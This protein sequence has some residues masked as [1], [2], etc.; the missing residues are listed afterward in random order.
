MMDIKKSLNYIKPTMVTLSLA[1]LSLLTACGGGGGSSN[2]S[3][4]N[5]TTP[6]PTVNTDTRT[7]EAVAFE[8]LNRNRT[9]CGFGALTR[10][11][12]LDITA[13][14][15]ANYM[16]VVSESNKLPI[17]SHE[18]TT[19]T[20][21][22]TTLANTGVVNPYFSGYSLLERLNPTTL[23][24][25]AVK[26]NYAE[27]SYAE[28]LAM[29]TL[30]TSNTNFVM[31]SNVAVQNRM[32]GLLAAPYHMQGLLVPQFKE[33]GIGYQEAKWLRDGI[34]RIG[35]ILEV[36]TA[37][38]KDAPLEEPSQTVSYPCEGVMT[39]YELTDEQPNPFA[40]GR[41][42]KIHPVGQ[43]IYVRA[44]SNKVIVDGS[45]TISYNGQSVGY[46]HKLMA[47]NDINKKLSPNEMV[48]IPDNKLQPNTT[49][50]V[51][52]LIMFTDGTRENRSFNF[53]TQPMVND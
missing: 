19:L 45:A 1:T 40:D 20:A 9:Q 43:P 48:F 10:N 27:S 47:S 28:N 3:I 12:A 53:T 44:P 21:N 49:Y 24:S 13:S 46:L 7:A 16:R 52:Y 22:G 35:S 2:D 11:Q 33:V 25:N 31:N 14:N 34:Y 30:S 23:G 26:T 8:L 39:A 15:H 29:Q 42:L 51:N 38:P 37:L 50:R 6:N 41:N 4:N 5:T 18:E 17:P 32:L 36:V